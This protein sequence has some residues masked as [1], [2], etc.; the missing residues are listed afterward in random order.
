MTSASCTAARVLSS[1]ALASS[2]PHDAETTA[3]DRR[4]KQDQGSVDSARGLG[5]NRCTTNFIAGLRSVKGRRGGLDNFSNDEVAGVCVAIGALASALSTGTRVSN[6]RFCWIGAAG[7]AGE[8]N[9]GPPGIVAH[10]RAWRIFSRGL[11]AVPAPVWG[12]T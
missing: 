9:T 1:S 8:W 10:P 3:R 12:Y 2:M 4:E 6:H 11:M 7:I 5:G